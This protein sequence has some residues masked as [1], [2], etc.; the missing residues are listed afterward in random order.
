MSKGIKLVPVKETI[1]GKEL[2]LGTFIFSDLPCF[3]AMPVGFIPANENETFYLDTFTV[4]PDASKAVASITYYLD[5]LSIADEDLTP[6]ELSEKTRIDLNVTYLADGTIKVVVTK[7]PTGFYVP[8]DFSNFHYYQVNLAENS[9]I[10]EHTS[11][12]DFLRKID[13]A[14]LEELVGKVTVDNI[15][16]EG[17]LQLAVDFKMHADAPATFTKI[18]DISIEVLMFEKDHVAGNGG[19]IGVKDELD[20]E[21]AKALMEGRLTLVNN[22]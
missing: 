7:E 4:A 16:P 8:L 2:L 13:L 17:V 22:F 18:V 19:Y 5:D 14:Q 11:K 12:V 15:A 10:I 20:A 3:S 21:I 1:R 9:R 6:T